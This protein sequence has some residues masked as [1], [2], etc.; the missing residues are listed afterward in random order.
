LPGSHTAEESSGPAEKISDLQP[1][2]PGAHGSGTPDHPLSAGAPQVMSSPP[3]PGGPPTL[4]GD[5]C[6]ERKHH[7]AENTFIA[8]AEYLDKGQVL[9]YGQAAQDILGIEANSGQI[10]KQSKGVFWEGDQA[11]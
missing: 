6:P 3:V 4:G 7:Q 9:R 2:Q 1:S 10:E 11:L 8:A 5:P